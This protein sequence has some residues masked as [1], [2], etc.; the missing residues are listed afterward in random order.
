MEPIGKASRRAE[1]EMKEKIMRMKV[2]KM[3]T[4]IWGTFSKALK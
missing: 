1:V 3:E 2:V 4:R